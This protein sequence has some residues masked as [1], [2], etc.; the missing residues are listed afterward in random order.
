MK[1][2]KHSDGPLSN[3]KNTRPRKTW[4][5][6]PFHDKADKKIQGRR[7]HGGNLLSK[8]PSNGKY[9]NKRKRT[10]EQPELKMKKMKG[11][12]K[13]YNNRS[14]EKP[15]GQSKKKTGQFSKMHSRTNK[16]K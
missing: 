11:E 10:E 16:A 7:N 4:N 9:F 14:D 13:K 3:D 5:E 1:K 12:Q 8:S 15:R 2:R 6:R